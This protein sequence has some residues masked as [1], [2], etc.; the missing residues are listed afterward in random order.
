MLD[1]DKTSRRES[2]AYVS[3]DDRPTLEAL[4][5][6]HNSRWV[7]DRIRTYIMGFAYEEE[8]V[9]NEDAYDI[10]QD[11]YGDEEEEV[12]DKFKEAPQK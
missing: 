12:Y 2:V 5:K 1:I 11:K 6:I 3:A 4:I 9:G 10:Y 7:P 8:D